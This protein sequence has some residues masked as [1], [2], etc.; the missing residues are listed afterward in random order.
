MEHPTG[1]GQQ[2]SLG[3][4]TSDLMDRLVGLFRQRSD[5]HRPGTPKWYP[6][7][8]LWD[9]HPTFSEYFNGDDGSGLGATHQTG[10]TAL[11]AYFICRGFAPQ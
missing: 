8:P 7:G 9:A 3:Q 5:G 4:I 11:V 6:R 10:W 2:R 1:S